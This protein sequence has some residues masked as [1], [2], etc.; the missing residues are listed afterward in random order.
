[1]VSC[2]PS[3]RFVPTQSD[4]SVYEG[5]VNAPAEKHTHALRWYTHIASFGA[6]KSKLPGEKIPLSSIPLAA[7]V[8]DDDDDV[9]LFGSDDEEEVIM[10]SHV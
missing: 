9:D 8:V 2:F 4:V 7:A 10:F 3:D 1:M 6:E 5:L